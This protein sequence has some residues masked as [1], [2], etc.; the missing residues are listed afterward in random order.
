M[1][2]HFTN[3]HIMKISFKRFFENNQESIMDVPSA[4]DSK[5][6]YNSTL[7][8]A[9]WVKAINN[10]W[11]LQDEVQ[12]ALNRIANEFI[13]F[14]SIDASK[15]TDVILTGSNANYNWS[16]LS[17]I[18]LHIILEL[19]GDD[20]ICPS[21]PSPNFIEDCFQ[22]KK[23]LWNSTH[24][25]T[26]H[27]FDVELYAQDAKEASVKNSGSYSLRKMNW[28][29]EPTFDESFSIDN[30][31]IKLKSE[32]IMKQIDILIDSETDDLEALQK[33]KERIRKLRS[34]GLS[35]GGEFSIENLA[36][37]AL[38]NLGYIQKLNNYIL[39]LHDRDL[40]I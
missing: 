31:A 15:V 22:A 25:I 27:G 10:T 23:T 5:L 33:L 24:S 34:S 36:F 11:E 20:S 14:L 6:A 4:F 29:Q 30:D 2:L 40:S 38:R 13:E 17:D 37:K 26:I 12:S 1:S 28:I 32:D 39:A 8:P 7:N 3:I 16:A 9:I 35:T 21:C 19:D 18:D